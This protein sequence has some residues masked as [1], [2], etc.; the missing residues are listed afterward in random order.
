MVRRARPSRVKRSAAKLRRRSSDR[1]GA[2]D[3]LKGEKRRP[4]AR[5]LHLALEIS[6]LVAR[7]KAAA[8][9]PRRAK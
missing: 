6:E 7:L 4:S 5:G 8:A 2:H 9:T 3:F 1:I